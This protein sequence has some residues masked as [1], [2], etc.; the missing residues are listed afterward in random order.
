M[1]DRFY[2]HIG[3]YGICMVNENILVIRKKL[4]PYI[5]QFDL[6]GGRLEISES[7]EQGLKREFIEETGF[8]VKELQNIG[9]CDFSVRWTHQDD[10]DEM[11][12]H[13]A[14][15]YEVVIDPNQVG[16]HIIQIEGQ[17]SNGY[18]WIS[19]NEIT[20][21]N[22]SPLVQ[23]ASEWIRTKTIPVTRSSFDYRF[24]SG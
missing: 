22:S 11:I 20:P 21:I 13:I 14:I 6:P 23:Q 8:S 1:E 24:S 3:V 15:L 16:G 9:V 17:D 12:H 19:I 10:S 5:S 4:G 2:R 7:L 18:D